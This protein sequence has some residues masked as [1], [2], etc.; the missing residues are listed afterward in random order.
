MMR[1]QKRFMASALFMLAVLSLSSSVFAQDA[2]PAPDKSA[3]KPGD[4]VIFEREVVGPQQGPG[5][6][7]TPP[8]GHPM[9][10]DTMVFVLSEMS[11]DGRVVKGAPY[12]AQATTE[13]E[14]K[15]M[16]CSATMVSP[17][18]SDLSDSLS[19]P[20]AKVWSLSTS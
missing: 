4:V 5:I 10:Q 3:R 1:M 18:L 7:V 15:L 6:R 11:I 13:S 16:S 20:S 19:R 8:P 2:P 14:L 12:S 9:G 17:A